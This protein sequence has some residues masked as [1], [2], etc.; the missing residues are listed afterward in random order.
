MN[1]LLT[2]DYICISDVD[3]FGIR[4]RLSAISYS[5]REARKR[6]ERNILTGSLG[7][8]AASIILAGAVQA[9]EAWIRQDVLIGQYD[10]SVANETR[11]V[12]PGCALGEPY[13]FHFKSGKN[14]KLL[15]YFNGGGACWNSN[16][17]VGS[18]YT[19]DPV[20]V[21]SVEVANDPSVMGGILDVDNPENPYADWSMPFVSY[22]TGDVHSGSNVTTYESPHGDSFPI[23]H[24]GFDNFL[25][26]MD[27]LKNNHPEI[28]PGKILAAGSSA[29]SY[30]AAL[31]YP[32]VREFYP[33][34]DKVSLVGDGGVGVLQGTYEFPNAV[35]SEYSVW[36]IDDTLHP[37]LASVPEVAIDDPALFIPQVYNRLR[38]EYPK[39]KFA[40]YTTA[41]DAVQIFFWDIMLNPNPD[42]LHPWGAG[43]ADPAFIRE[44][45]ANMRELDGGL[46]YADLPDNYRSY[47][48]AGCNHT[49]LRFDDDFY[50]SSL[51]TDPEEVISFIQWLVGMT[52]GK[53]GDNSDWQSLSCIPGNCGEQDLTPIGINACLSRTFRD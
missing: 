49:I 17:C 39:D 46:Q 33:D 5:F 24:R 37:L 27:W 14:D 31:N 30:G 50:T 29:G 28:N 22:C 41:Y 35:F 21:P 7:V 18:L 3:L 42:S 4:V 11:T 9:S 6:M 53:D 8:C 20:Y 48:G 45:S 44:W 34:A 51:S 16:T 32:W 12:Y 13:A 26:A 15:V 43:L 1:C 40:Q 36:N 23:N 19:L 25:F 10:V 52:G 38:A 47:I 2:A